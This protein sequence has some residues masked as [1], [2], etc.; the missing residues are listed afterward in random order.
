MR[1]FR[2]LLF[3]SVFLGLGYLILNPVFMHAQTNAHRSSCQSNLKQIGM[4]CA[5]YVSDNDSRLLP[6]SNEKS[7]WADL[8]LPYA[9]SW[10]IFQCPSGRKPTQIV[11]SDYF[12]NGR[13]AGA[14]VK[15]IPDR[16]RTI[17]LGEGLDNGASNSHLIEMPTDATINGDS[18]MQRHLKGGNYVFVDGHVKWLRSSKI[19]NQSPSRENWNATF[20][21]R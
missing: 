15:S 16:T 12:F 17:L 2:P 21:V 18:P 20:A 7:G 10:P 6:L 14:K 9:K 13:L 4:A 3:I 19:S 8:L 11:S 5:Q 1:F